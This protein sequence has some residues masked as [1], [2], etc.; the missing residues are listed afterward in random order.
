LKFEQ[1]RIGSNLGVTLENVP[2]TSLEYLR[3]LR[4]VRFRE[5][6]L[7]LLA[8]QYEIARIDEGGDAAVIQVVDPAIRP[9]IQV[10]EWRQ[11][12]TS[13]FAIFYGS[14]CGATGAVFVMEALETAKDDTRFASQMRLVKLSGRKS[15]VEQCVSG[16]C[17]TTNG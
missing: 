16:R 5:A 13:T 12:A 10:F 17:R 7:E 15:T 3:R 11:R 6:L 4:E 1:G 9:E 2:R 8:N 14:F